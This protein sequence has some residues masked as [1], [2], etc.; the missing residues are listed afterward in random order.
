MLHSFQTKVTQGQVTRSK[1]SQDVKSHMT[2]RRS[3]RISLDSAVLPESIGGFPNSLAQFDRELLTK[4]CYESSDVIND[5]TQG[6]RCKSEALD[7]AS[8]A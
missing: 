5:V 4:N 1:R 3:C 2:Q 6:Q 8:S 7:L